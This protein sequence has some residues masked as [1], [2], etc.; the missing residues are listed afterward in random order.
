MG[1]RTILVA[2]SGGTASEGAVELACRLAKRHEAHLEAF[3]V[4]IDPRELFAAMA[5]DG[6]G[7]GMP[8]AGEWL[9]QIS[10][11]AA[12]LAK[13]TK[14]A[15]LAA[16]AR[17]G[18]P[19]AAKPLKSPTSASWREETGYAPL[20]VSRRARFFDL[21]ILGR[22]DR[23]VERPHSDTIEE[24]LLHSGR[25]ALLAPA[26][27]PAAFGEAIA[28]GWNGS[29]QAVRALT[30]SLPLLAT[31]HTVT[32]LTIGDSKQTVAPVLDYLAWQGVTAAHHNIQ[33]IAGVGAGQQLLG[34]ARDNGADLLVMGGYGHQPWREFLFGGA[35]REIVGVSLLPL[36][37]SH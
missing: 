22:S 25:P 33:S 6:F 23:V 2:A 14:D 20:L 4:R 35:T 5:G 30:L 31:A 12:A 34:A 29:P 26:Q 18:L 3:H 28:I 21:I 13:K 37:L 17:H 10:T 36:L 15:F 8:L 16:I 7:M 11:D 9:E 32:V 1:I 19:L 27:V 24:T